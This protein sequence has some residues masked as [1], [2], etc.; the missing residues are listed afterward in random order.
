ME[1]SV[2]T[3]LESVFVSCDFSVLAASFPLHAVN[4][5]AMQSVKIN[6]NVLFVFIK[7]APLNKSN[8]INSYRLVYGWLLLFFFWYVLPRNWYWIA[9]FGQALIQAPHR[10]HSG[11]F[12]VLHTSIS[13][14][15]T[16]EHWLHPIHW[17]PST[18]ILRK[19]ILLN[20]E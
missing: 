20:N 2:D 6:R 13:I 19:L 16:F 5:N 8:K 1:S 15:H 3:E 4:N 9:S 14:L 11:W 18:L 10:I 12:G 7:N 17:L